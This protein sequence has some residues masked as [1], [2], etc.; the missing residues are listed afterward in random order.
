MK[1]RDLQRESSDSARDLTGGTAIRTAS[2]N[3]AIEVL[4]AIPRRA[5]QRPIA[6]QNDVDVVVH[7]RPTIRPPVN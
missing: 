5:R 6:F 7:R 2:E 3:D 4:D 1:V